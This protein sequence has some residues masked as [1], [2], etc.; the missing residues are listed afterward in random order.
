MARI[1]RNL[2][3]KK[4]INDFFINKETLNVQTLKRNKKQYKIIFI[5]QRYK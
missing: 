4:I 3:F 2:T 5:I 1:K